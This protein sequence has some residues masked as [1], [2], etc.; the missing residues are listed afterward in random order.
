MG[1]CVYHVA[2][3][4][5]MKSLKQVGRNVEMENYTQALYD[6]RELALSR[7]QAEAEAEAAEGIVGA[8]VKE[9]SHGWGSHVIEYFAVGTAVT[10]LPERPAVEPPIMT[11]PLA[12]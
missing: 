11:L 9:S 5:L 8:Q 10:S 1:T 6:A 4:G 7:M 12:G 3:Q 2:H